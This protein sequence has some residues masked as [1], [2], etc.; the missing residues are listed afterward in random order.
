M[1]PGA[2]AFRFMW[3]TSWLNHAVYMSNKEI[4]DKINELAYIFKELKNH[5]LFVQNAY[6]ILAYTIY[7]EYAELWW[8]ESG[9]CVQVFKTHQLVVKQALRMNH[10]DIEVAAFD[11]H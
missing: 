1:A 9:K 11:K 2:V 6:G 7:S 8:L 10:L 3:S 5:E 4:I